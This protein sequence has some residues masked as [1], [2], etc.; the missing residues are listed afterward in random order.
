MKIKGNK[1][2]Q[3]KTSFSIKQFG[4]I[5]CSYLCIVSFHSIVLLKLFELGVDDGKLYMFL[6]LL[7]NLIIIAIGSYFLLIYFKNRYY[8]TPAY[9][10]G[11]AAQK[12]ANGDFSVRIE[13]LHSQ[14]KKD[15]LD[16]LIDNFN[17]M[18]EELS[19]IETLKSDFVANI[20]HEL[21]SPLTVIQS[22]T[23]ALQG[24]I[25]AA[26]SR[27]YKQVIIETTQKLSSLISNILK[28]NRLENQRIYPEAA[29]YELGEQIRN[30]IVGFA[31]QWEAKN[32]DIQAD[33][34][35]MIVCCDAS[36]L[37]IAWN[38]LISNAIKYTGNNG[39]IYISAYQKDSALCV[40]IKDTGC[41]MSDKELKHIFDKFY[42]G[43]TPYAKSGNGLGLAMV[44]QVMD[45]VGAKISVSSSPGAGTQFTV[46]LK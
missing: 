3:A 8:D 46:L 20:S 43:D 35:D 12:I 28:L 38:N 41:G 40:Q 9:H 21:K 13:P 29:P 14:E 22:Y 19:S 16:R 11:E 45:I 26:D 33:I 34:E 15:E 25:S 31:A 42:Q 1:K 44:W 2:E 27:E 4:V 10:L 6:A 39:T 30:C 36:L 18:A 5:F 23:T 7:F 24:D 32:I 17:I 37:E